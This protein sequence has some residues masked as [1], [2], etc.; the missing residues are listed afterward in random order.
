MIK[1]ADWRVLEDH[2]G[3][4]GNNTDGNLK[5]IFATYKSNKDNT[6]TIKN[7]PYDEQ[8]VHEC[9]RWMKG[10]GGFIIMGT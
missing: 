3:K 4:V 5:A 9:W 2:L 6:S 1:G 8:K 7:Y 10:T